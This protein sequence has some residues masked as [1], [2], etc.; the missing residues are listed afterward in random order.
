MP[1]RFASSLSGL[2]SSSA[3]IGRS[4]AHLFWVILTRLILFAI[5]SDFLLLL[6]FLAV[7]SRAQAWMSLSGILTYCL[8]FYLLRRRRNALALAL[9]WTE[10]FVHASAGT[11]LAGWNSG[12]H[13]YLLMFAPTIIVSTPRRKAFWMLALLWSYY[14]VLLLAMQRLQPIEP[15]REYP[16]LALHAFNASALFAMVTYFTLMYRQMAY[17]SEQKLKLLATTDPLTGLFNRRHANEMVAREASHV[18]RSKRPLSF[19]LADIDH[20]KSINDQYGHDGGDAVLVAVSRALASL[21]R[22]EDILAR[23]GGEEFLLVLPDTPLVGAADL[24]NRIHEMMQNLDLMVGRSR[25]RITLSMGVT[26]KRQGESCSAALAR[27]DQALY[28]GKRSGRNCV[29]LD[30]DVPQMD[31]HD[32]EPF[33]HRAEPKHLVQAAPLSGAA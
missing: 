20:F 30:G 19:I 27:A 4:S 7:D 16:L 1:F 13:Y 15:M 17:A 25:I 14:L 28:Q 9:I 29:K 11:F 32:D 31:M 21:T 12:F 8:A 33:Y 22:A 18:E 26:S 6:L 10:V 2:F 5:I 24:A 3:S 23:W